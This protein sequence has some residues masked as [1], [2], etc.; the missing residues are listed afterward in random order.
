MAISDNT[1][2]LGLK[3]KNLRVQHGHKLTEVASAIGLTAPFLSMVEKGKSRVSFENLEK[4]M[5]F[6]GLTISDLASHQDKS[7][8]VQ[9]LD[10]TSRLAEIAEGV[11]TF[12]LFHMEFGDDKMNVTFFRM[13]PG[14]ITCV[15]S[16]KGNEYLFVTEG[17]LEITLND[18]EQVG[19]EQYILGKWDSIQHPSSIKH[20]CRNN[21]HSVVTTFIVINFE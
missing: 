16:H 9:R 4:I 5:D 6:Y 10:Q 13:E 15:W 7:T 11:E 18:S 2:A 12:S 21:S 14:A 8:M 1:W 19:E 20:K 3:L 17:S